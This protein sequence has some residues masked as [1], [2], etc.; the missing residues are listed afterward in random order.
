MTFPIASTNSKFVFLILLVVYLS[1]QPTAATSLTTW[2]HD[3]PY[4]N[5]SLVEEIQCYSLP[6]GGIG[7][8]SHII[9]YYT[10]AML[11]LQRHPY[12]PW[13]QNKHSGF[14]LWLSIVGLTVTIIVSS[15][16]M[17]RCRS[18]WQFIVIAA[19]KLDLSVTFGLLSLHAAAIIPKSR[20]QDFDD[21]TGGHGEAAKVL[22]WLLLYI[23]GVAAGMAGLLS[24]VAD[25][26]AT[27]HNVMVVTAVFGSI[28]LFVAAVV[29]L[30]VCCVF[31]DKASTGVIFGS[32]V[33]SSLSA[34]LVA[35]GCFGILG[36]FYSDWILASIAENMSGVP[37]SDNAALY[38]S[39]FV[40]K[41]LPFFSS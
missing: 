5:G 31:A 16:T 14:D 1:A 6:Y 19:W 3:P 24:L 32:F 13:I 18:K 20:M 21:F 2:L 7:F 25:T 37:S 12:A 27:N 39:Y 30:I 4:K 11:S 28:T 40:A 9:T 33:G 10:I 8:A 23:P 41:R 34:C 26:I 35:L 36:A 17:V 22:F 29:G 15:L 38:W